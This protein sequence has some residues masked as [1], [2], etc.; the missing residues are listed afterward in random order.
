MSPWF[1]TVKRKSPSSWTAASIPLST[2]TASSCSAPGYW[3]RR[4][5]R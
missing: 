5:L 2:S 3:M 1:W 4:S